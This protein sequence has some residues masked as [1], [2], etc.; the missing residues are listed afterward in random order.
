MLLVDLDFNLKHTSG[1]DMQ[2]VFLK[3]CH[4]NYGA[5]RSGD[6]NRGLECMDS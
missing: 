2:K 4:E 6:N 1:V 3:G 5:L